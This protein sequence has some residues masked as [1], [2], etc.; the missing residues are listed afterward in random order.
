MPGRMSHFIQDPGGA[1]CYIAHS[2]EGLT[3]VNVFVVGSCEVGTERFGLSRTSGLAAE[4]GLT[5][6]EIV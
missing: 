5:R 6:R 4:C 3:D 2:K 1:I